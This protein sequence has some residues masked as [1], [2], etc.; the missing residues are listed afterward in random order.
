MRCS[1]ITMQE[2][3][4][5]HMTPFSRSVQC[6]RCGPVLLFKTH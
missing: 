2:R 6:M 5:Q 4:N 1:I 3:N